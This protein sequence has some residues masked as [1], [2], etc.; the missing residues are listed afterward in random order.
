METHVMTFF[1]PPSSGLCVKSCLRCSDIS[2]SPSTPC[3]F[4]KT[5]RGMHTTPLRSRC[6]DMTLWW[7]DVVVTHFHCQGQLCYLQKKNTFPRDFLVCLSSWSGR[8]TSAK[9]MRIIFGEATAAGN[10]IVEGFRGRLR[11]RAAFW[12]D[13]MWHNLLNGVVTSSFTR[14]LIV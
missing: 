6:G 12:T 2:A 13:L 3:C 14:C 5:W 10:P 4:S 9:Q 8:E 1:M 7:H 11:C